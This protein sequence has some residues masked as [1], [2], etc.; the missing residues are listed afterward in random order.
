MQEKSD[1]EPVS[2]NV[3]S[4]NDFKSEKANHFVDEIDKS[5]EESCKVDVERDFMDDLLGSC[6]NDL[7]LPKLIEPLKPF[8]SSYLDRAEVAVRPKVC[9]VGDR[10]ESPVYFARSKRPLGQTRVN[11]MVTAPKFGFNEDCCSRMTNS[12]RKNGKLLVEAQNTDSD[13]IRFGNRRRIDCN[14]LRNKQS[15]ERIHIAVPSHHSGLKVEF[16][17]PSKQG[18]GSNWPFDRG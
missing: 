4:V 9:S 11:N 6:E 2:V 1:S 7:C 12:R 15:R 14:S 17:S 3:L 18:R 8:T 10:M 16:N 13:E 5:L